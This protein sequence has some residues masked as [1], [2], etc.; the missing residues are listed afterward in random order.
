M[1]NLGQTLRNFLSSFFSS[2]ANPEAAP[3]PSPATPAPYAPAHINE[4]AIF[5]LN[6]S[7]ATKCALTA[8]GASAPV[9]TDDDRYVAAQ[10]AQ[11]ALLKAAP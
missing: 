3:V 6:A 10:R 11:Q 9:I 4:A 7:D 8:A 1:K 2:K 5:W